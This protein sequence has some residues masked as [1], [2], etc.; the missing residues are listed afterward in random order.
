MVASTFDDASQPNRVR[1]DPSTAIELPLEGQSIRIATL[2]I[3]DGSIA[4]L[5]RPRHGYIGIAPGGYKAGRR[6]EEA[7]T[8]RMVV[9]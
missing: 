8:I 1:T 3:P 5:G 6:R 2:T 4:Y 7:S 9:D